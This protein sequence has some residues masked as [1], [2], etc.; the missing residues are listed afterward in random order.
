MAG[1][2]AAVPEATEAL[3]ELLATVTASRETRAALGAAERELAARKE[4]A[5]EALKRVDQ[6]IIAAKVDAV[7]VFEERDLVARDLSRAHTTLVDVEEFQKEE[8]AEL[9]LLEKKEKKGK[10]GKKD[11]KE[12]KDKKD[13]KEEKVE[14][15]ETLVEQLKEVEGMEEKI[16][17]VLEGLDEVK[18]ELLTT[19]DEIEKVRKRRKQ[20]QGKLSAAQVEW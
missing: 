18:A 3:V 12:K 10:K 7:Q 19:A 17:E 4:R 20:L 14:E 6:E 9:A 8:S 15:G 5:M 13:K 16:G 11:K 2:W 1:R